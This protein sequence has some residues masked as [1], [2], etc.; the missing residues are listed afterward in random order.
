[1]AGLFSDE[2]SETLE[3]STSHVVD[4]AFAPA[5]AFFVFTSN[6]RLSLLLSISLRTL[7]GSVFAGQPPP[8]AFSSTQVDGHHQKAGFPPNQVYEVHGYALPPHDR[9]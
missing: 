2:Q 5:D 8:A 9:T 6:V 1:M 7:L 4:P 3:S